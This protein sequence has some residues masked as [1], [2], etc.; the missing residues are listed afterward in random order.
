MLRNCS[1]FVDIVDKPADVISNSAFTEAATSNV[2][3]DNAV[4]Q[5]DC[6]NEVV[7]SPLIDWDSLEI[8][9]LAEDHIRAALPVMDE[10]AMYEFVGLR[11][12]D[13]RAEQARM[14]AE[15]ENESSVDDVE[16]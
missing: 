2:G 1:L 12:E 8:I 9:P 10:E 3:H 16:L 15:K 5:G 4:G 14:A 6:N 11:V 13:E 7:V